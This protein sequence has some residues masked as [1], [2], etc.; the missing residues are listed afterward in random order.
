MTID[1]GKFKDPNVKFYSGRPRGE[2]VRKELR[3]DE[4]ENR[5]NNIVVKVPTDVDTI[6]SSFFLGLFGISVR[7]CQ[8]KEAFLKKFQF[9]CSH[10][11]SEDVIEGIEQAL[12][13]SNVLRK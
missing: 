3:L 1:L 12:K 10:G 11:V 5:E 7:K 8:S 13:R 4:N 6:H 2:A 9:E